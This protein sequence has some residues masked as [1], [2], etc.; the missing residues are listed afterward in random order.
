[1]QINIECEYCGSV[2]D[3]S[4]HRTCPG[5]AAVPSKEQVS[6]ARAA[7]KAE[8]SENKGTETVRVVYTSRFMNVV[9]KLIPVCIAVILIS[10]LMPV[11]AEKNIDSS[12][13]KNYQTVDEP[14][15]NDFQL[16]EPFVFDDVMTLTVTEAF[17][18]DSERIQAILPDGTE[19]LVVHVECSV[20]QTGSSSFRNYYNRTPYI[21][22]G[23]YCRTYVSHSS[24]SSCP[25]VYA[26]NVFSLSSANYSNASDGYMCFV[27]NEGDS[28]F[29]LC[30][31]EISV[32][33]Y[34]QQLDGIDRIR[35]DVSDGGS[36]V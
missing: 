20:S 5:C 10:A 29:D 31:E 34:A 30:F 13:A 7:A 27:V 32:K 1:M 2:Y 9:V 35:I 4:K 6:A 12:I 16:N 25:E 21:D 14:V 8:M 33:G 24:L 28:Q 22:N 36:A 17:I 26:Q 15:Y 18:S 3:F 11:I 23:E 19:L